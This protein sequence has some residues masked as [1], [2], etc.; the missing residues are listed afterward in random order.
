MVTIVEKIINAPNR[1]RSDLLDVDAIPIAPR[2]IAV[3]M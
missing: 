3:A 1:I 2:V